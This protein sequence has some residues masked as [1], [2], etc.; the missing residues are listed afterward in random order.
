MANAATDMIGLEEGAPHEQRRFSRHGVTLTVTVWLADANGC[1]EPANTVML[2]QPRT[3]F[4]DDL[5]MSGL[6]FVS[7]AAFPLHSVVGVRLRLGARSFS[8]EALVQWRAAQWVSGKR[9][10]GCGVQFVRTRDTP[11]ALICIAKYL[12]NLRRQALPAAA[13]VSPLPGV[14]PPDPPSGPGAASESPCPL[15]ATL[16]VQPKKYPWEE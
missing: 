15:P 7:P 14:R 1:D 3:A 10:H 5:S 13:P 2:S 9:C 8:L 11:E 16:A 12:K 4:I 6:R